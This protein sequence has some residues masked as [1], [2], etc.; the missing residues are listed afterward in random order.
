MERTL[1][2]WSYIGIMEKKMESTLSYW[3]YIGIME[4][5]MESTGMIGVTLNP[6]P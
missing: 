1:S 2:Y 6:K 5:K 3:S 4:K